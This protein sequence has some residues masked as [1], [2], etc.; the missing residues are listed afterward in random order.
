MSA[1]KKSKVQVPE[2]GDVEIFDAKLASRA[3]EA[4][5]EIENCSPWK[6]K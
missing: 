1:K 4:F 5:N 2:F 3:I 6:R